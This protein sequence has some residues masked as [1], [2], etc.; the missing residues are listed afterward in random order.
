MG[1]YCKLVS[2]VSKG[3]FQSKY[4]VPN[5]Q[6]LLADLGKYCHIDLES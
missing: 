1:E 5:T 3:R 4:R 2:R 6:I